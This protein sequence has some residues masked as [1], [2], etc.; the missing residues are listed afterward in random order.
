MTEEMA[1]YCLVGWGRCRGRRGGHR[2][3]NR[4]IVAAEESW[5]AGWLAACSGGIE[6]IARDWI[7]CDARALTCGQRDRIIKP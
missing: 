4:S 6:G 5:C 3:K 7:G 1:W 2:N